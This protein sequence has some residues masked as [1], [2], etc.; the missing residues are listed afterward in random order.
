MSELDSSRSAARPYRDA[1]GGKNLL[2]RGVDF[3]PV[4][5]EGKKRRARKIELAR[6]RAEAER[7]DRIYGIATAPEWRPLRPPLTSNTPDWE[8]GQPGE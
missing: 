8:A 4:I 3:A 5:D 2:N 1:Y 7:I 6:Q